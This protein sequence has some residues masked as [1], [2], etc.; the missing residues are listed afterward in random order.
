M[1]LM[2]Q[3]HY[4]TN[5]YGLGF[6]SSSFPSFSASLSWIFRKTKLKTYVKALGLTSTC[7]QGHTF[8]SIAH[9]IAELRKKFSNAGAEQL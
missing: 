7:S 3:K 2:L 6:V 1:V 8:D 5:S 9:P 4:D